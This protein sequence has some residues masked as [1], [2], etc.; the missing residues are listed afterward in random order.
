M[1][2]PSKRSKKPEYYRLGIDEIEAVLA[3]S[4]TDG[5]SSSE[6]KAR[7]EKD[8]PNTLGEEVKE[9]IL[10]RI[11]DELKNPLA[12]VLLIA[13]VVTVFLSHVAD[14]AVIFIALIINIAINLYQQGHASRAFKE[15]TSAQEKWAMVVRDGGAKRIPAREVVS[16][17]ILLLGMGGTVPADCR[18]VE[19]LALEVNESVLTGEWIP[20]EKHA[21]VIGKEVALHDRKN[22]LYSG[23]LLLSGEVRA[24]VTETGR[25]TEIGAIARE[26]AAIEKVVTPLQKEIARLARSISI[27]A[28]AAL[29]LLIALGIFRKESLATVFVTAIAI[30]VAAIPEGLPAA[31]STTLAFAMRRI[32][33]KGGLVRSMLAAETL[34]GTTI[35]VVDK[36]GTLTEGKMEL[37]RVLTA[38][39]VDGVSGALV[40]ARHHQL[41]PD[42]IDMLGF[43]HLSSDAKI[44]VGDGLTPVVVHG[45]AVEAAITRAVLRE[46]IDIGKLAVNFKRL[47]RHPFRS[48]E[49]R[50]VTLLQMQHIDLRRLLVLGAAEEMLSRVN[51]YYK[52]GESRVLT[53]ELRER[54]ASFLADSTNAGARVVAICYS[55]TKADA[56]PPAGEGLDKM[57]ASNTF[58]FGAFILLIDPLRDEVPVAMAEARRAGVRVIM[59]T[60][61]NPGT[62]RAVAFASGITSDKRAR[63]VTGDSTEDLSDEELLLALG[64]VD[65]FARMLPLHKERIAK[66]LRDSGEVVAMTGDGVNDAPALATAHIGVALG[67]G[68][69]VAKEAA[70]LVLMNNSFA[71]II[72]AIREGR[73]ALDNIRKV[74]AYLLLMSFQEIVL[75]G[76]ASILGLPLPLLAAQIL[77]E[78]MLTEGF[79]NFAFAAEKAER[80]V[81]ERSPRASGA[82]SLVT[83]RYLGFIAGNAAINAV[84]LVG[85]Y[86]YLIHSGLSE[87]AVRTNVFVTLTL[88][89]AFIAYPLKEL[90]VPVWKVSPLGNPMFFISVGFALLGLVLAF[91]VPFLTNL[92]GVIPG[93]IEGYWW[94][95]AFAIAVAIFGAEILKYVLMRK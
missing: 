1:K 72:E 53:E 65:V 12:F 52:G 45:A 71:V 50:S 95:Q 67:S 76:T 28:L 3:T 60:G 26:L 80:G 92:L 87:A 84:V 75:I 16:G 23:T 70:G 42:A 4:V 55:D 15:L 35:V 8:G 61:D 74:T 31:V 39:D 57:L 81:M 58:V 64:E 44:E 79:M 25:N 78:N 68:T 14:A 89:T 10:D 21:E 73:R 9:S 17:D 62:A 88:T 86:L 40:T 83:R 90:R 41:S 49:R 56:L 43:A 24:I 7:L 46:K 94:L 13:G 2:N 82:S 37:S 29:V 33:A 93:A 48:T 30:A 36:T 11:V 77:W 20:E 63:V 5:L 18:I 51:A 6:A 22:M 27:A 91:T 47:A 32:L 66:I 85:M 54:L 59:A 38:D 19:A 34:G 69:D